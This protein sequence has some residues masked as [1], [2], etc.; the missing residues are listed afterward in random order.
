M[1]VIIIGFIKE[2]WNLLLAMSP[3]LLFGFLIA[4][5]LNLEIPRKKI[6]KHLSGS[7]IKSVVKAAIF[8]VPLPLCSCGVIPVAAYLRKEGAG[9]GATV[10]FLSSTPTTGI[11]SIL[12]TYSL[13]GPIFAIIR[14]VASF[15]AGIFGGTLT[16]LIEKSQEKKFI[17]KKGFQ[18]NICNN[19]TPHSHTII[20]KVKNIFQ[21]AFVELIEDIAKWILIGILA[22]GVISYLI[23]GHIIEQYLGNPMFAYPL[24][25]LVALP[26]YV[27]ATGSIP[28]AASLILK[29]MAPGA[30]LVFLIAGPATNTATLS[31]VAGKLGKKTMFIYLSTIVITSLLFGF[32]IDYI[33]KISGNNINLIIGGTKMLPLW[34]KTASAILLTIFILKAFLKNFKKKINVKKEIINTG[35]VFNVPDMS[36]Q[37]CVKT[38]DNA[39]RKLEDI[40]DVFI[41]L[42]TKKVKII[43]SVSTELIVSTIKSAGYSPK[44]VKSE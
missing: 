5:I 19:T 3:Y 41:N 10:S 15:F 20:E 6:Y 43:G 25:L 34:L 17:V 40:K 16:N 35:K 11:D 13:L 36:C 44:E 24:M 9:K 7:N 22:G 42:K 14:P 12:A 31:F 8:G 2:V 32:L 29:G 28:I 4:G 39:I 18:C 37:H 26:M 23:P 27:C 33:W 30:G 21:Y 38:I 1:L